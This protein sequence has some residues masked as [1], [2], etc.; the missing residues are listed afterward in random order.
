MECTAVSIL[1]TPK[2]AISS[3]GAGFARP[4]DIGIIRQSASFS[5]RTWNLHIVKRH[6]IC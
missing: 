2:A 6:F 4:G 1:A 3:R 5:G